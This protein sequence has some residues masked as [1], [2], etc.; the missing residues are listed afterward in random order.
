LADELSRCFW[1]IDLQY[2]PFNSLWLFESP[3]NAALVDRQSWPVPGLDGGS[4]SGLRPG[5]LPALADRLMHDEFSYYF[6]IDA[7]EEEQALRR[8]TALKGHIGDFS[9]NFLQDLA[10]AADL[11]LCD[12]DGWWE[13]Y[14]G[15]PDWAARLRAAWPQIR[16]RPLSRGGKAPD[17]A[18]LR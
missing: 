6:A 14:C 1:V 7:P 11:F 5:S 3:E 12:A 9:E 16:E 4:T 17:A 13:M 2:G 18:E 8:A 15:R 10:G